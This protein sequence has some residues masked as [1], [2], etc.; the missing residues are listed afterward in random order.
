MNSTKNG[1]TDKGL[2]RQI[3]TGKF[4]LSKNPIE[5]LK[6]K[7]NYNDWFKPHG[8]WYSCGKQWIN[9]YIDGFDD[10]LCCYLYKI[11][12]EDLTTDLNN[13]KNHKILV[14]N[15]KN[16]LDNFGKKY[17]IRSQK[18][19]L[20]NWSL[21][22]KDFDGIEFCPYF[23]KANSKYIFYSSLDIASGCIWNIDKIKDLYLI[24]SKRDNKWYI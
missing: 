18:M 23:N 2:I 14:V 20:I 24:A 9:F 21:V 8:F 22:Y 11:K 3:K 4:H 10:D 15:S 7:R 13:I 1:F 6:N 12:I 17:R 16:R 19:W 5:K